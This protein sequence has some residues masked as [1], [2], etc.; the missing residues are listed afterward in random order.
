[1]ATLTKTPTNP[2]ATPSPLK[3]LNCSPTMAS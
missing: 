2:P 1:M 3:S